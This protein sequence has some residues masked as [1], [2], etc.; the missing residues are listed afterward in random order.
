MENFMDWYFSSVWNRCFPIGFVLL[1][2]GLFPLPFAIGKSLMLAGF[3][4]LVV[5]AAIQALLRVPGGAGL[6]G[7]LETVLKAVGNVLRNVFGEILHR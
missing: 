5:G 7:A 4:L 2:I 3:A 1:I 6:V